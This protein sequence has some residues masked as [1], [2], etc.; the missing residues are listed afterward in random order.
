MK[1]S[2]PD[3]IESR[4]VL[5]K[6][7]RARQGTERVPCRSLL[8]IES[9]ARKGVIRP[10]APGVKKERLEQLAQELRIPIRFNGA[11]VHLDVDGRNVSCCG[12]RKAYSKLYAYKQKWLK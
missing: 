12:F 3:R 5:R 4:L 9:R 1:S 8:E 2:V 10:L 7:E 11:W 6:E